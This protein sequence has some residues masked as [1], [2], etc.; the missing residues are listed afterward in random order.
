MGNKQVVPVSAYF[1]IERILL[2]N[3]NGTPEIT[4]GISQAKHGIYGNQAFRIRDTMYYIMEV[5]DEPSRLVYTL[6]DN[7]FIRVFRM[8]NIPHIT[9]GDIGNSITRQL[10][11]LVCSYW[12]NIGMN[13]NELDK[14]EAILK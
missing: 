10:D 11:P 9:Y 3:T 7:K 8:N 4:A 2:L 13:S 6:T 12:K 1:I 5:S 14:L